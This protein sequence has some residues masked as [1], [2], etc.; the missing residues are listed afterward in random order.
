MSCCFG[1]DR[2]KPDV[3]NNQPDKRSDIATNRSNVS[4]KS[5]IAID[6]KMKSR[7]IYNV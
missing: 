1:G 3:A 4:K 6:S 7:T 5:V 2:K